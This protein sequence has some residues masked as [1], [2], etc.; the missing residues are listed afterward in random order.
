MGNSLKGLIDKKK[1]DI[2]HLWFDTTIQTYAP[3]TARFYKGQQDPF[4]NPVG[5]TASE[6]LP[7]LLDQLLPGHGFHPQFKSDPQG[8]PVRRIARCVPAER[9]AGF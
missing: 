2:V 8:L 1:K 7:F 6:N 9:I 5:H 3:D 4:A